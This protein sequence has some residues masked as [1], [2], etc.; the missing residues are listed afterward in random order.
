M[1]R[2]RNMRAFPATKKLKELFEET[3]RLLT[4]VTNHTDSW[5]VSTWLHTND[6]NLLHNPA[7]PDGKQRY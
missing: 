5:E 7:D 3:T 4:W 6:E 1:K 2:P